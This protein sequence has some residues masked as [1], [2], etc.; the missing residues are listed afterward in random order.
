MAD[1]VNVLPANQSLVIADSVYKGKDESHYNFICRLGT[2]IYCKELYYNQIY[3][4]QPLF[5]HNNANCELIFSVNDDDTTIYVV[6]ATPFILYNE[7]DGNAPGTS[8]LPPK[9]FSYCWNMEL[10][11]NNDVRLL[12]NNAVLV[13]G[14][15]KVRDTLGNIMTFCFRYAPSKGFCVYPLQDNPDG[16]VYTIKMWPCSYI[17]DAHFTHGFGFINPNISLSKYVPR[18]Y[19]SPV[20]WSDTVPNLMPYRY[21]IVASNELTKD[22]RL[23]SF[24]NG[25]GNSKVTSELAIFATNPSRTRIYT[26]IPQG[27]SSSVVSLRPNYTP[28]TFDISINS[29]LGV[30]LRCGD[31]CLLALQ[32]DLVTDNAKKSFWSSALRNRGNAALTNY[33]VFGPNWKV[34]TAGPT[35]QQSFINYQLAMSPGPTGYQGVTWQ[36]LLLQNPVDFFTTP[37]FRNKRRALSLND[38]IP[39]NQSAQPCGIDNATH[40]STQDSQGHFVT[41]FQWDS[42]ANP[43]PFLSIDLDYIISYV[44]GAVDLFGEMAVNIFMYDA[45]DTPT[46]A[47]PF[48]YEADDSVPLGIFTLWS[49]NRSQVSP[50]FPFSK[51]T[52]AAIQF[53]MQLNPQYYS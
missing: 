36:S 15:G 7:F 6:Y 40:V 46:Q 53:P 11:F 47:N 45:I 10:G 39:F 29:E 42:V 1:S 37:V 3:W 24:S 16:A 48:Y 38:A 17:A 28:L 31:G 49:Q 52:T 8:L 20:I 27:D 44:G 21:V 50:P 30:P 51:S 13:N 18:T 34:A 33:L 25:L 26:V 22:R 14:D 4:S 2:G 41:M 12:N 19:Y 9:V 35:P 43:T 23:T 5:A 32:D